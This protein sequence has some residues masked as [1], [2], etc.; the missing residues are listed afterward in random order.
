MILSLGADDS[1][2]LSVAWK[3]P[4]HPG[5]TIHVSARTVLHVLLVGDNLQMFRVDALAVVAGVIDLE[6]FR[7][8]SA[9]QSPSRS[10]R[11]GAK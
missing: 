3:Y 1:H 6:S 2:P 11:G 5:L 8:W 7:D 9:E 4:A 10:M